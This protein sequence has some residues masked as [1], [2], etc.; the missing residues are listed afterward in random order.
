MTDSWLPLF[1]YNRFLVA[2]K[3]QEASWSCES[4]QC[5]IRKSYGFLSFIYSHHIIHC[6]YRIYPLG[7]YYLQPSFLPVKKTLDR[8]GGLVKNR[9]LFS[10]L[11]ILGYSH[12]YFLSDPRQ[13]CIKNYFSTR[14]LR[15]SWW[16]IFV[17]GMS[18]CL[19]L[20]S[21]E[22][23]SEHHSF[24]WMWWDLIK[25]RCCRILVKISIFL[26]YADPSIK[27]QW[28]R[29]ELLYGFYI[30]YQISIW[31]EQVQDY[32]NGLIKLFAKTKD[33]LE[34]NFI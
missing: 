16:K 15:A 31:I 25:I 34:K 17:M 2:E 11:C 10:L 8:L 21:G 6:Q 32:T 13:P 30:L 19:E 3:C 24:V 27:L 23:D 28:S 33:H 18:N 9:D 12:L 14:P 5:L 7:S 20:I 29:K 22:R 4:D 1:K 26:S